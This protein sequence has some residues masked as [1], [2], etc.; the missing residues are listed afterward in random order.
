MLP[1]P[2]VDCLFLPTVRLHAIHANSL[3]PAGTNP[4]QV[5]EHFAA[6]VSPAA[7]AA[8]CTV[9]DANGIE[10]LVF[11]TDKGVPLDFGRP[12]SEVRLKQNSDVLQQGACS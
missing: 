11:T 3:P 2:A 8:S 5:L 7:A 6:A 9:Q 12:E 1:A 4:A 10:R